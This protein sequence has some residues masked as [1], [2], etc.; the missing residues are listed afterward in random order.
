MRKTGEHWF[1][2]NEGA[3]N[4][5]GF[6]AIGEGFHYLDGSFTELKVRGCF[7][8][9]TESD[10]LRAWYR[11]MVFSDYD[12]GRYYDYKNAGFSVRCI[13]D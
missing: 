13:K 12:I 6:T 1:N 11:L 2:P 7:W 9:S 5:T 10:S 8:S 4:E 3:T